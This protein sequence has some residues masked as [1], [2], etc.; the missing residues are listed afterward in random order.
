MHATGSFSCPVKT[1][2][3]P[4][5]L[6]LI[7]SSPASSLCLR[8]SEQLIV[9]AVSREMDSSVGVHLPEAPPFQ[10]PPGPVPPLVAAASKISALPAEA[11]DFVDVDGGVLI[12]RVVPD[13][14]SCLFSSLALI[15]EQDIN[16]AL[17]CAK[18]EP[19]CHL[20]ILI[21]L[22]LNTISLIHSEPREKY[23]STISKSSSWG[24]AIELSILST[25]YKTEISSFDVETGR[26][27]QFGEGQYSNRCILMYSG[28]H[29][30]AVSLG[31]THDAP[32][33][34]HQT[35]F[36][37]EA[38]GMF[39]A[40]GRLAAKR[41][42]KRAYTNTATFDLRCQVCGKG[43]KGEK[44]AREHAREMNHVEFGEY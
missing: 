15:F 44:E 27:D 9:S 37:V 16:A 30:D 25:H 12:L 24:G 17:G 11:D 43:L 26:C 41:R 7:P 10:S 22:P 20:L 33:D 4:T 35:I 29:Y 39:E 19:D 42:Q 23:I 21:L 14:N 3:P 5:P 18:V 36:P 28:I 31:P 13:D 2:Y 1:G 32:L 8:H 6:T 40:A 34:F 38:H